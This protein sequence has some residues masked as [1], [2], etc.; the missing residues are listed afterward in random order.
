M[1]QEPEKM[2]RLRRL[3]VELRLMEGSAEILQRRLEFLQAALSDLRIAENSLRELKG[4]EEGSPILVPIGGN[5]FIGA[6][7]GNL[8]KVIVGIGAD[9]SVEMSIDEAVEDISSRISEVEKAGSSV[10]QQLE[11]ITA[12]IQSHREMINELSSQLQGEKRGV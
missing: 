11:Q 3:V 9:V 10:Q 7:L 4:K 6:R 8:S 2:E 5:T 1:T 12:Q